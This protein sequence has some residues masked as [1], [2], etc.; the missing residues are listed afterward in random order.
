MADSASYSSDSDS[1]ER[2][3]I[4]AVVARPR[5]EFVRSEVVVGDLHV[6]PETAPKKGGRPRKG[7]ASKLASQSVEREKMF[8]EAAAPQDAP[9]PPPRREQEQ[10]KYEYTDSELLGILAVGVLTGAALVWVGFRAAEIFAPVKPLSV[11]A[12]RHVG[13]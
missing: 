6:D 9:A 11:K 10:Q 4:P 13:G 3:V 8:A 2:G 7:V 1:H 12:A 5:P